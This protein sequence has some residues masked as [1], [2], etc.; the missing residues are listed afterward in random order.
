MKEFT[1]HKTV[2]TFEVR[3]GRTLSRTKCFYENG[4]L[5]SDGLYTCGA[6]WHW[7]IPVGPRKTYFHNGL[8]KTEEQY[9]DNGCRDGEFK[10]WNEKGDLQSHLIYS[11]DKKILEEK[12]DSESVD[13]KKSA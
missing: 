5:A 2:V 12:F 7:D 11:K 3:N 4:T 13:K 8:P 9:D 6:E 10:T 1:I